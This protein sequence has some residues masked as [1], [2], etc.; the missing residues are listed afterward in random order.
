MGSL[1]DVA[2]GMS[3]VAASH[4][5]G[6]RASVLRDHIA[7]G[8]ISCVDGIIPKS[9][10]DKI[11]EQQEKYISL[12]DFLKKYDDERFTSSRAADRWKYIDFLEEHGC[13]G[14]EIIDSK[15]IFFSVPGRDDF[16]FLRE[17][18]DFLD[19]ESQSFFENF[20]VTEEEKVCRLLRD[21][22]THGITHQCMMRYLSFIEDTENIYTP[23]LT[24]FIRIVYEM[25]DI[26][27]ISDDDVIAAIEAADTEKTKNYLVEFFT[28]AANHE[29]VAYH[30]IEIKKTEKKSEP[31]YDYETFVR[32]AKIL[33]NADYDRS[34]GMTRKALDNSR[35][36][37]MW[38]FL[39]C[40]YVCGWRASDI[41]TH[42]VYPGLKDS[43]NPFGIHVET[44]KE[45][46][47]NE[48]ITDSVYE[49]VALYTVRR[50]EM[51]YNLPQKTGKGKLR[52][53]MVPELR[54][55]F[56]KLSLIAEYHHLHSGEGYMKPCRTAHYRNWVACRE[57]FGEEI[58]TITGTR[59]ISSMRLNKSYL[60][61]LEQAS[62][63]IGNP[64]LVSHVVAAYARSHADADTTAVYLRDHGL[65]GETAGVVLFMM[66]QRGVF[67]VSLYHALIMAFPGA[68]SQ[69]TSKEQSLLMEQVP[70]SAFELETAGNIFAAA[71][72]MT[73]ELSS[74]NTEVPVDVLKAMLSIGQGKGK[75]KEEGVYCCRKA[76]G[77]CCDRPLY[78]SCIANLCPNHIFTKEGIPALV[79]VIKDY[80]KKY[81]STGN[82][83]YRAAME[84]CI[85]PA[86][87]GVINEVIRGMSETE[88]S[89]MRIL[90]GEAL[91]E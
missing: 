54:L 23:S 43:N 11:Q 90:I 41:C 45:D 25:P 16:Y 38:M 1:N 57:F 88:R 89:A 68:F 37:E 71:E 82:R 34:H 48:K 47:L 62:R 15:K 44:L 5:T 74:G 2:G 58:F 17:D 9:S 79:K 13:F 86:F 6:I 81:R 67:G 85:I 61:G 39:S 70:L 12:R 53:E 29:D 78:E 19:Y 91:N 22:K 72:E 14:L 36:A 55:F 64:A 75:A 10:L 46:I 51:S 8:N 7:A 66:M 40:H 49:N 30:R 50:I 63:D 83:K 33:F 31:A 76:L 20:G 84:K 4:S 21:C 42:W 80:G 3:V 65:T 18:A 87:Q 24:D 59:S 26:R 77:L 28:Y 27:K 32:L 69:L 60:Q 35:Y 73:A 52:S 56:G